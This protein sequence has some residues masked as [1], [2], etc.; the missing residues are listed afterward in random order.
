MTQSSMP[1]ACDH[2]KTRA[3]H[4]RAASDHA[5]L[6][7]ARFADHVLVPGRVPNEL[8]IGFIDAV[9]GQ[10]FALCIVSNGRSHATS[11]RSQRHFHFHPRAA[12]V[13]LGQTAIINQAEINDVDRDLRIVA[14]P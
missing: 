6:H 9:D 3:E 5:E 7:P 13:L 14:L 10:D 2:C 8:D 1:S 4:A 12:V 11:G